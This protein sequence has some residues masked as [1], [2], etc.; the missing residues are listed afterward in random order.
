MKIKTGIGLDSNSTQL[1]VPDFGTVTIGLTDTADDGHEYHADGASGTWLAGGIT[2]NAVFGFNAWVNGAN[3][4]EAAF[5]FDAGSQIPQGSQISS[6]TFRINVDLVAGAP[7]FNFYGQDVDSAS[8]PS[9]SNLPTTW[10][11]T[12]AT[13]NRTDTPTAD[14]SLDITI[15]DIVQEIID[16]PSW[17]GGRINIFT[18]SNKFSGTNNWAVSLV[19]DAEDNPSLIIVN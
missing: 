9:A 1:I 16:R 17:D 8:A 15:T 3:R 2:N 6:A 10:A 19:P 18:V 4:H 11:H 5:S 7:D 13:V 14:A 12:S